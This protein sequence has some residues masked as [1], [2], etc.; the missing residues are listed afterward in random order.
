MCFFL[1]PTLDELAIKREVPE[2]MEVKSN[3]T[4]IYIEPKKTRDGYL[5]VAEDAYLDD[6]DSYNIIENFHELQKEFQPKAS[7]EE[8]MV[9]TE[10]FRNSETFMTTIE[11]KFLESEGEKIEYLKTELSKLVGEER[12]NSILI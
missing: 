6:Y 5:D 3:N 4:S 12:A 9:Q 2:G 1:Q 7:V 10:K 8:L 11:K